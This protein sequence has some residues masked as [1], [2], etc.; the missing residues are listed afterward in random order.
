MLVFLIHRQESSQANM[1]CGTLTWVGGV[2]VL[3]LAEVGGAGRPDTVFFPAPWVCL[4]AIVLFP[5]TT[6]SDS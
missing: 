2:L 3:N 1:L 4:A 6:G 5:T